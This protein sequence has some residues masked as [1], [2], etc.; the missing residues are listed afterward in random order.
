M[1][2]IIKFWFVIVSKCRLQTPPSKQQQ[3][4]QTPKSIV[5]RVLDKIQQTQKEDQT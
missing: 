5:Q 2:K 1:N 3:Q 4:P